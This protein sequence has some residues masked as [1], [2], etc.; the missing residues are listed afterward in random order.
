V[1]RLVLLFA[2][3][4][5]SWVLAPEAKAQAPPRPLMV[6]SN[7][8]VVTTN[9]FL[10]NALKQ[11]LA[12]IVGTNALASSNY[13]Y[14]LFSLYPR[15]LT[16]LTLTNA[17]TNFG[18]AY[19][20]E[21]ITNGNFTVQWT[22]SVVV[23]TAS[24]NTI[25]NLPYIASSNM[26]GQ[27]LEI[28]N[29]G[30]G[31]LT[32]NAGITNA[33]GISATNATM[34][35]GNGWLLLSLAGGTNWL[36]LANTNGLAT[37]NFVVSIASGWTT[38]MAALSN[39]LQT[40]IYSIGTNDTNYAI[41]IGTAATNLVTG[42]T[43]GLVT[44]SITNGLATINLAVTL[45]AND[46]NYATSIGTASTNLQNTYS[47]LIATAF[48][49][50]ANGSMTVVTQIL[51][52]KGVKGAP[53]YSFAAEPGLGWY[54]NGNHEA[55]FA[56]NNHPTMTIFDEILQTAGVLGFTIN[57]LDS[58]G[59][60]DA[61]IERYTT[62][63]LRISADDSFTPANLILD[64]WLQINGVSLTNSGGF[65]QGAVVTNGNYTAQGSN[66]IVI[67]VAGT[68]STVN[69]PYIAAS[70]TVAQLLW[71][72]NA[73]T[74]SVTLN[75]GRTNA[76]GLSATNAVEAPGNLWTLVSLPGG[77][78]WI[79]SGNTNGLATTNY[80]NASAQV[81]TNFN[82]IQV[83]NSIQVPNRA[84]YEAYVGQFK[85]SAY[86]EA[87]NV[88]TTAELTIFDNTPFYIGDDL[89]NDGQG[90]SVMFLRP[91][92]GPAGDA[93]TPGSYTV[94]FGHE[95]FGY[96]NAL[97]SRLTIYWDT[98]DNASLQHRMIWNPDG[99]IDLYGAVTNHNIAY[100]LSGFQVGALS[101]TNL[102][103]G[104][105]TGVGGGPSYV[106]NLTGAYF[107]R[108]DGSG[109]PAVPGGPM[110]GLVTAAN[111][112]VLLSPF[113]NAQVITNG[114][115]YNSG[116][117]FLGNTANGRTIAHG[118]TYLEDNLFAGG[119]V[120]L[121][122]GATIPAG[123]SLTNL[124]DYYGLN[125]H[126]NFVTAT[127]GLYAPTN[128][129]P[130]SIKTGLAGGL[131]ARNTN[132]NSQATIELAIAFT[133][134]TTGTP[135]ALLTVEENGAG[136][137]LTN[138][139]PMSIPGGV[140]PLDVPTNSYAGFRINPNAVYYVTDASRGTGA[141]IL[142]DKFRIVTP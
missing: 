49:I 126:A 50:S 94:G 75:A 128:T 65:Y 84:G 139:W 58:T 136:G 67:E 31:T 83:T 4:F 105:S 20:G 72:A 103:I 125:S 131:A 112:I 55:S 66:S 137:A 2:L 41:S 116:D 53:A 30:T 87:F 71:V 132:G 22:N 44:A 90:E 129:A 91:V 25:I 26:G 124:G 142:V 36:I 48:A 80:V 98:G 8:V 45:A 138:F 60:T 133:G 43:N 114:V 110:G 18:G 24:T 35:P 27:V 100:F 93:G 127:N 119:A 64:G 63:T 99:S 96:P 40:L 95:R 13:V 46:T 141:S 16:G 78:N 107:G 23:E 28:I 37:T 111:Q 122:N 69:L 123:S 77:T 109:Y 134:S 85:S 106:A 92:K 130:L 86:R 47:N 140:V 101:L 89:L 81:S 118:Q 15:N 52:S 113:I 3:I 42:S 51:A 68:N 121:T 57:S 21:I 34:T 59:G 88:A 117:T 76:I 33:I 61:Q 73:G 38:S 115:L 6:D 17:L 5:A 135:V 120:V 32:L 82:A 74:G 1:K 97:D 70:G 56:V 7:I 108:Y 79:V 54:Y 104:S 10:A 14:S 11:Q 62:K 12:L 102:T 29:D 19:M 39:M 9:F